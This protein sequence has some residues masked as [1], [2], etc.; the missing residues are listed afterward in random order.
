VA[1]GYVSIGYGAIS[2]NGGTAI[3]RAANANASA[4]T[5]IGTI[6]L[7]TAANTTAIGYG[8][9]ASYN[10]STAIGYNAAT[11]ATNEI[12]LG[13]SSE[14]VK[15][16][17]KLNTV[18]KTTP[19]MNSQA[20]ASTLTPNAD[21]YDNY[22]FTALA[23][24]CTINADAGTPLDGQSIMFR[25]LD[26]GTARALTWTTGSSGAFRAIGITLPTTTTLSKTLYVGGR[27]NAAA[28][29]WDMLATGVEA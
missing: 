22:A 4:A 11:G 17:G 29:R 13:T 7:A 19:R 27:Y 5:A 26:N 15:I 18:G 2:D 9:N 21:T 20:S 25:F 8:S 1:N 28:S 16:Y 12:A 6:A 3:G 14:T 10:N 24:A 23:A